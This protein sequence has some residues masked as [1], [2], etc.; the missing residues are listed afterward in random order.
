MTLGRLNKQNGFT[1]F[2]MIIVIF[3][4]AVLL[5]GLL[6][7]FD[8]QQKVYNLEQAEI[9]ATGSARNAMNALTFGLAQGSAIVAS[10]NIGGTDYS[11]SSSTVI[12]QVPSYDSSGNLISGSSDYIVYTADG[13][14]LYQIID[15]AVGSDRPAS[16]KLLTGSLETFS[17]TYNNPSPTAA[18]QV[19]INL[20]TRSYYRGNQSVTVNL[21]QTIFLRN[22]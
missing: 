15:P 9:A 17:L 21:Q 2:E 22:I 16:T 12:V 19:S 7:M 1:L 4:M 6:N 3:L 8:W 5:L 11:T 14:S 20:T 13:V 10:R 18:S